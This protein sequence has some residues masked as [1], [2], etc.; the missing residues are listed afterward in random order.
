MPNESDDLV[1][2][3]SVPTEAQANMIAAALER[4]G[5]QAAIEGALTAAFRAEAPG[6]VKIIVRQS[7]LAKA[8]KT[9]ASCKDLIDE[10]E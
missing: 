1:V 8:K 2:L 5:I 4:A 7:D 9:L 3:Q 10:E 6:E